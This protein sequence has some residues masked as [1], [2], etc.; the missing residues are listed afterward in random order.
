M[1]IRRGIEV[2]TQ[3]NDM[4]AR[5]EMQEALDELGT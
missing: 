5:S 3:Q 4:H 2:A 1:S